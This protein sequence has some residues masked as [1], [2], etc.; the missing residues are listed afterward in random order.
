MLAIDTLFQNQS[1]ISQF[2]CPLCLPSRDTPM[3]SSHRHG[4]LTEDNNI[5]F[6]HV[7]LSSGCQ[8]SICTIAKLA[9]FY[10]DKY[11]IVASKTK[12]NTKK[13]GVP[14]NKAVVYLC[15]NL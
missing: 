14:N 12:Q 7:V 2:G 4:S 6:H 10:S 1:L 11:N 9:M 13:E 5:L 3:F 15:K 8:Y